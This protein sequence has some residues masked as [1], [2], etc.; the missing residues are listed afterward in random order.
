MPVGVAV[1]IG[2]PTSI[3]VLNPANSRELLDRSH[4]ECH[5][6]GSGAAQS[7][8]DQRDDRVE[9][10]FDYGTALKWAGAAPRVRLRARNS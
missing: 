6:G 3:W 9:G 8:L 1:P 5:I 2:L 7:A 10:W 4:E